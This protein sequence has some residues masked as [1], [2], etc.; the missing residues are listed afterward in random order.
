VVLEVVI[1]TLGTQLVTLKCKDVVFS[2]VHGVE[3]LQWVTKMEPHTELVV[4]TVTVS[5]T[6][7][8]LQ[9]V[10]HLSELWVLHMVQGSVGTVVVVGL[11]HMV[12]VDKE[13]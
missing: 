4:G 12:T 10:L 7:R 2:L 6:I 9:L 1:L 8:L 13:L 11:Y 3:T 5:I